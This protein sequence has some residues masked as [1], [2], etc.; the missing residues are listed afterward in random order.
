MGDEKIILPFTHP[1]SVI[2]SGPTKSGKTHFVT[3]MLKNEMLNPMPKKIYWFYRVYQ[4][5]YEDMRK[6]IS[7]IE[8]V[9]DLP[10]D[11]FDQYMNGSESTLLILDDLM[12]VALKNKNVSDIFTRGVHHLNTSILL[13]TQNLFYQASEQRNIKLNTQVYVLY[14][15][16]V[17]KTQ[18]STFARAYAPTK[19]KKFLAV[20]KDATNHR[21]GYLVVDVS[22]ASPEDLRLSSNIFPDEAGSVIYYKI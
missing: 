17:D 22:P 9:K 20:F 10:E 1:L 6:T 18:I 19:T 14:N 4:D 21:F 11:G 13:I 16:I 5:A 2:V 12:D 8:F 15:N 7:N 3:K